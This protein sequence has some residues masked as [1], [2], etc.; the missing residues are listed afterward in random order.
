MNHK[1]FV[2]VAVL[3][4]AAAMYAQETSPA[5]SQPSGANATTPQHRHHTTDT[6][7]GANSSA[8]TLTGCLNGPN[9]ENAYVLT[10][11]SYKKGVEVGMPN[12]DDLSK[13]VGHK[14]K[15]TGKWV[16]SGN[17]I[18]ENEK[19]EKSAGP[20]EKTGHKH[21]E[22]SKV[23]HLADSCTMGGN[24]KTG[25]TTQKN[26]KGEIDNKNTNDKVTKRDQEKEKSDQTT[27]KK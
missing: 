12:S 16:S 7:T 24:G 25:A 9:A 11:A 2:M 23:D 19:M 22:V 18:G 21:F 20:K 14:V 15:L 10:N 27:P 5:G 1:K 8:K 4:F 3:L 13:H 17:E 6:T 26:D